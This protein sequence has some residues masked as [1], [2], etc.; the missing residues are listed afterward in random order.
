MIHNIPFTPAEKWQQFP[1]RFQKRV[2]GRSRFGLPPSSD[3][4]N[5]GHFSVRPDFQLITQQS[6]EETIKYILK[7]IY[8]S[9]AVLVEKQK[10][11]G[12]FD[13]ELFREKYVEGCRTIGYELQT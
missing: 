13:A 6:I 4:F 7:L 3:K 1:F 11:L 2:S 8:K 9:L 12:G 10:K 5:V